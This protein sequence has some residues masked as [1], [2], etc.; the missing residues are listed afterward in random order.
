M[1]VRPCLNTNEKIITRG[2]NKKKKSFNLRCLK[3]TQT[4]GNFN[5][6]AEP[7]FTKK[8]T[9]FYLPER[10]FSSPSSRSSWPMTPRM[11]SRSLPR[12]GLASPSSSRRCIREFCSSL[13][14]YRT[15]SPALE[16]GPT[17]NLFIPTSQYF[18]K[19]FA[20]LSLAHLVSSQD[21]WSTSTPYSYKA[22]LTP[23][24]WRRI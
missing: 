9:S 24:L 14:R 5:W 3:R 2:M 13:V 16:S 15:V 21:V 10:S 19:K 8:K 20:Y 4:I 11:R 6:A 7:H 23:L 12:A 1:G 18:T 17:K 22:G